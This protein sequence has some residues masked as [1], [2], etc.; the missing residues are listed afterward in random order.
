[1]PD[2]AELAALYAY[3]D[4]DLPWLRTNF[5]AS[6]DGAAQD[7]DGVSGDMGGQPDHD[8]FKVL[9]S[10][11]DVVLVGAGTVR[12][13][14][15]RPITADSLHPELREGLAPLPTLAV[16]SR[17]LDIPERL[18][19]PGVVVITCASSPPDVRSRLAETVDVLVAGGSEIDWAAVLDGFL[20]RGLT[21]ILCEGG[22]SLHGTLIGL[23]LVEEVCLTLSPHL[24]GGASKRIVDGAPAE[25]RRMRLG[26]AVQDDDVLLTRW[27]RDRSREAQRA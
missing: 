12:V 16:V 25:L 7:P 8:A 5:V 10:L 26:H 17:R 15:Y 2:V 6:V 1:M 3:P 18:L 24:V 20:V 19:V 11:C 13:E 21:R 4:T 27:V 9:R 22:P 14:G 23:D